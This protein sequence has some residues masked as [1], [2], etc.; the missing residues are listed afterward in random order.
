MNQEVFVLRLGN[1]DEVIEKIHNFMKENNID[2]LVPLEA[3]GRIRDFHLVPIGK[4]ASLLG[5]KF[6]EP[7][8]INS[9]YG[10]VHR[11]GNGYYTNITVSVSQNDLHSRHGLLKKA[12]VSDH[13]E[14]KMRKINLKKII[15]A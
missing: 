4:G 3:S 7:F 14:L 10:K 1:G 8:E 13:L 2:M 9:I 11:D 12:I 5:S 15:E 6:D